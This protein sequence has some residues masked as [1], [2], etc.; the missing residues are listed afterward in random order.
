[1]IVT[2]SFNDDEL[3]ALCMMGMLVIS[4]IKSDWSCMHQNG[5]KATGLN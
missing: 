1:M 4:I 5:D 2:T 3:S